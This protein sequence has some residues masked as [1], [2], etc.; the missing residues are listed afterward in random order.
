MAGYS[1]TVGTFILPSGRLGDVFG[2]KRL[3]LLGFA[4]FA[5]WSLVLG[6]AWWSTHVLFVFARVLQGVG[7]A[8][9]LTNGLA[10]LG[11][12][13][14]PGSRKSMVFALFG[15]CAPGGSVVGSV[16]ASLF[17]L[18]WWPWAFFV[19]A[20]VLVL[21]VIAGWFV[22]PDPPRRMATH[23][24][25]LRQKF[26][27]LDPLGAVTG[28]IALVLFNFAWNQAPIVSWGKP[29]VYVLLIIGLLFFVLFFYIEL[30]VSKEPLI[31]FHALSTDV[32]FVLGCVACG[33][34]MFG[35]WIFYIWQIFET[36][37]GA[38]PL[39]ASAY[40]SPVTISG[41]LAAVTTG[42]LLGRLRPAYVMLLAMVFFTVGIILLVT[43]P[44]D[45]IYWAQTFVCTLVIPWGMDMSFPAA[46]LILSNAV[47]K[48]HQ[49]IAAS[50]VNTVVNYSISLGLGLAGTVEVHVNNG[51]NTPAQ[52]LKGYRGGLYMGVGL[53][54]LGLAIAVAFLIKSHVEERKP[55]P[56]AES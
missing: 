6:L 40:L 36:L 11:A 43:C 33:W 29:Y 32:I 28:V 44:V 5:L 48:R 21:V 7:P 18:V 10:L 25:S 42:F 27:D 22:I 52:L 15:A 17:G 19:F 30:R 2:Y 4:W 38:S 9:V 35:I 54:G 26:M 23:G 34:S 13:Y 46:T 39:L 55:K 41:T 14:A 37:R 45:Q 51:G 53:A 31:P 1:L 24:E 8:L 49:G 16:F 12:S 20:I 47:S 50:L 56:T 3:F